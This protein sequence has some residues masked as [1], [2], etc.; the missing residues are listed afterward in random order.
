MELLDSVREGDGKHDAR[1]W[2]YMSEQPIA[3]YYAVEAFTF[4]IQKMYLFSPRM[5]AQLLWSR[6]VN[7]HGKMKIYVAAD[8]HM[9]HL[10]R[11]CKDIQWNP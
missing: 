5:V 9:E 8:L 6:T 2:Q 1:V 10:N 7:V 4:L 3:K 11:E